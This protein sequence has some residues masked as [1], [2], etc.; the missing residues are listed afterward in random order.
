MS[1]YC[2]DEGC[3]T[4]G[5]IHVQKVEVRDGRRYINGRDVGPAIPGATVSDKQRRGNARGGAA[6]GARRKR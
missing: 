4:C 2:S 5:R 3:T 6:T 1:I